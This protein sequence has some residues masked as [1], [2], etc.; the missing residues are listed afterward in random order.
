M[1]DKGFTLIELVM[2]IVLL[3]IIMPGVMLYFIQGVKGSAAAQRRTTAIFLAEGLME[4]IKSK[5]W[6]EV[7]TIDSDCSNASSSPLGPDGGES[8]ATYDDIDD[9]NGISNTPPKDSQDGDMNNYAGFTQQATVSYVAAADL[10]APV[11]GPTCYKRIS[12]SITDN[13]SGETTGLVTL[14]TSY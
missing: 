12:V 11:G 4:E 2:I 1:N 10:N 9:F 5:S 3:G 8:R 14:M 7:T 6:D 13:S